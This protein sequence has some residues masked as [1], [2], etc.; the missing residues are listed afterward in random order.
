MENVKVTHQGDIGTCFAHAAVKAY[1]S[2]L[3][4]TKRVENKFEPSIFAAFVNNEDKDQ[5]LDKKTLYKPIAQSAHIAFGNFCSLIQQLKDKGVCDSIHFESSPQ[6]RRKASVASQVSN[7]IQGKLNTRS[8]SADLLYQVEKKQL[9]ELDNVPVTYENAQELKEKIKNGQI[10]LRGLRSERKLIGETM[11]DQSPDMKHQAVAALDHQVATLQ[12]DLELLIL[13]SE[14]IQKKLA[15]T[16]TSCLRPN[17][18]NK[19]HKSSVDLA[20][21]DIKVAP[22]AYLRD[23]VHSNCN[24]IFKITPELANSKCSTLLGGENKNETVEYANFL[25]EEFKKGAAAGPIGIAYKPQFLLKKAKESVT[26]VGHVSLLIGR[27]VINGSCHYL[28]RNSIGKN[29]SHYTKSLICEEGD[30]WVS[31]S[32]LF[33]NTNALFNPFD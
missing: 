10:L 2:K 26:N 18:F 4:A 13:E 21:P 1:E 33:S 30:T 25:N 17:P 16:S 6:A 24:N 23:F 3:K 12:V 27:K 7:L 11:Y 19:I 31:D 20:A 14:E 29:C 15:N 22:L 9:K 32:E 5:Y 28:I 8:K